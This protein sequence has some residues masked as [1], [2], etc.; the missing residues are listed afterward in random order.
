MESLESIRE[1]LRSHKQ[2]LQE[3]FSVKKIGIFGSVARGVSGIDSDVD[4]LVEFEKPPGLEFMDFAEYLEKIFGR[5]VDVLTPEGVK[6]IR[7]KHV[8]EDIVRGVVYV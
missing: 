6:G 2:V 1:V 4:V 5:K 7:L 8:A 3:R